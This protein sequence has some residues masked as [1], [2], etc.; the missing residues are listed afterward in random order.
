MQV[1]ADLATGSQP[2]AGFKQG[3]EMLPLHRRGTAQ[4]GIFPVPAGAAVR[5]LWMIF[6][7]ASYA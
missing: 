1:D 5:N 7:Y 3:G 4:P 2:Q 6:R